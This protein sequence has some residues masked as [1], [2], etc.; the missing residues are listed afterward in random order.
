LTTGFVGTPYL[1]HVLSKNGYDDIAYK[2]VT[3]TDYPSW[4]YQVT[5]GATTI[6]EH[7]DGIKEDGSFWSEA[8]NSFNHYAYGSI[9]DWLY[10]VAAG[11]DID[12]S[13][14]G[15][16]HIIIKPGIKTGFEYVKSSLDTYYGLIALEWS[17]KEDN[18]EIYVRIPHNTTAEVLLPG[19]DANN[20]Y[21]EDKPV[22]SE[23]IEGILGYEKVGEDTKLKLGSGEYRF[24]TG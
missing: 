7:W 15:Y 13:K 11:I 20:L 4:L 16:K 17:K 2:L 9:G 10:R 23:E 21:E 22:T 14:P 24:I 12:E 8:M 18:I 6:W 5:K 3:Q 1:C 19:I